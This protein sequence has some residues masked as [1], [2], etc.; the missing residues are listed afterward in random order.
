MCNTANENFYDI[1]HLDQVNDEYNEHGNVGFIQNT[2]SDW[3]DKC[4]DSVPGRH[5]ASSDNGNMCPKVGM[6]GCDRGDLYLEM[7]N[8]TTGR[9]DT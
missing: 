1:P 2:S 4:I 6:P 8:P 3:Y 5:F 7:T 9:D